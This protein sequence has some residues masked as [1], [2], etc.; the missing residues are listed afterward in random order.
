MSSA[1]H[2]NYL[3]SCRKKLGLYQVHVAFIIG[4]SSSRVSALEN[5]LAEPTAFE[6]VVFDFI[7]GRR[8]ED[9]W[10]RTHDSYRMRVEDRV[11][12]LMRHLETTKFRSVRHQKR[13]SFIQRQLE[14]ILEDLP[15]E[16]E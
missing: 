8:F 12:R 6:S 16:D 2:K 15:N 9:L 5:G 14:T 4:K 13:T 1:T 7:Y 10:P 3:R 11:R